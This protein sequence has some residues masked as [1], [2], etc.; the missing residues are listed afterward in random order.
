KA[1][2]LA[3]AQGYDSGYASRI[4]KEYALPADVAKHLTGKFGTRALKI[5]GHLAE[6]PDYQARIADGSPVLRAEI[7]YCIRNEMA[8][9]IEDLLARRTGVQMYSWR[10]ALKAAPVVGG[11]LAKEKGWDVTK[12]DAAVREYTEKIRGYLQ[13]L[14]LSEG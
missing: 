12:E 14:E 13:E 11:L 8:E 9:N 2:P 4:E 10:G 1:Y 3:G 7:V 5:I 6:N